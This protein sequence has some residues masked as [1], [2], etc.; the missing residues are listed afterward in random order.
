MILSRE[1]STSSSESEPIT[2][3]RVVTVSCSIATSRLAT[4]Y[5]ARNGVGDR[6]VEDRVDRDRHVVLGDHGLRRE[7]DHL[8]PHVDQGPEPVDERDEEVQ[9]RVERAVVA[10]EPLDDAGARLRHDPNGARDRDQDDQADADPDHERCD[11]GDAHTP[12]LDRVAD[13]EP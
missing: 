3:R 2:L 8:L 1:V 9:A 12:N 10:T 11:R 13:V 7:G 6:E 4:S 5:V